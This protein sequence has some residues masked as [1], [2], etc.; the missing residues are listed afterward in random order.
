MLWDMYLTPL[1]RP[2][3]ALSFDILIF[4]QTSRV[5]FDQTPSLSHDRVSGLLKAQQETAKEQESSSRWADAPHP[6]TTSASLVH[7][8]I[9]D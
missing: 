9:F 3:A 5:L 1:H 8:L 4:P 7:L 6:W 2:S